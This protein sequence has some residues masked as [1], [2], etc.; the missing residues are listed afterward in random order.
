MAPQYEIQSD[1]TAHVAMHKGAALKR[2][3]DSASCMRPTDAFAF[4][5]T[6]DDCTR[7]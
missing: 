1:K 6:L 7:S 4:A 5:F 3:R 2:A